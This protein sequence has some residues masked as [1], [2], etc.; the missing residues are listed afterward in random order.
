MIGCL[1]PS[2]PP[3]A[4]ERCRAR[5]LKKGV[6]KKIDSI[7]VLLPGKREIRPDE[8]HHH[9][10]PDPYC[11]YIQYELQSLTTLS[12]KLVAFCIQ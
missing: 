1:Y 2:C 6:L 5:M 4:L 12:G 8:N 10:V 3:T 9:P 11:V 7:H